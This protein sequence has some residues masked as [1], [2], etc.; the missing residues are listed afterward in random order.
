MCSY[1]VEIIVDYENLMC[2]STIIHDEVVQRVRSCMPQAE[3]IMELADFFRVL[4]D[5]T[6]IGILNALKNSEMCVCDISAVLKMTH[7]AVSHQLRILKQARLVKSR[8]DGK[9]VYY[10]LDDNH[11][12][13]ILDV[14]EKHLNEGKRGHILKDYL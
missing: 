12:D 6:R 5:S 11:I 4:G 2:E 7:S 3:K 10:S 13:E 8:K 14:G 9:V 1:N